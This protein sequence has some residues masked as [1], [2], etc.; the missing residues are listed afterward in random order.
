[1]I[2]SQIT[3]DELVIRADQGSGRAFIAI[4]DDEQYV[5][6]AMGVVS[7]LSSKARAILIQSVPITSLNWRGLEEK[8]GVLIES[9]GVRQASFIGI[10]AGVTLV[11]SRA[12][13]SPKSVRSIAV[14][15]ATSRPH[16]S[17]WERIVDWVEGH[18]PFGL[19]LRLGTR[20]FNVRAYLHRLRCPILV[21]DSKRAGSFVSEELRYLARKAPTAWH[22]SLDGSHEEQRAELVE[23]IVSFQETPAKCPQKNIQEKAYA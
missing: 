17:R 5:S 16:P 9:L 6:L 21:I 20:G 14:I 10:G 22:I 12:L 13:T 1:M 18:L 23:A 7:S 3:N 11:Q 4:I 15:D 19:P 2:S 8:L